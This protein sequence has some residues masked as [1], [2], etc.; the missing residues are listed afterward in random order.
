MCK[1]HVSVF[2]IHTYFSKKF[3]LTLLPCI[4]TYLHLHSPCKCFGVCKRIYFRVIHKVI[5]SLGLLSSQNPCFNSICKARKFIK[6]G[7]K[8]LK[9]NITW[10]R[11]ESNYNGCTCKN[12][13]NICINSVGAREKGKTRW[14]SIYHKNWWFCDFHNPLNVNVFILSFL[15]FESHIVYDQT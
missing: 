14:N 10:T 11:F 4:Y 15:V 1:S 7:Y 6:S 8:M 12:N 2:I 13:E 3:T 9:F 5:L